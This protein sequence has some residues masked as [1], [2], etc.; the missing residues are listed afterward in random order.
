MKDNKKNRNTKRKKEKDY[1]SI[2]GMKIDGDIL[3]HV[4][5]PLADHSTLFRYLIALAACFSTIFLGMSYFDTG[6]DTFLI[7]MSTVILCTAFAIIKSEEAFIR[8][9]GLFIIAG[10]LL[11]FGLFYRKIANGFIL[12]YSKYLTKADRANAVITGIAKDIPSDERQSS[13]N[14]FMIL[15]VTIIAFGMVFSCLFRLNVPAMIIYS[16]PVFELGAY[17][18]WKP[19]TIYF[20]ILVICWTAVFALQLVNYSTNKAGLKNT[21]AIHP[22]KRTFYF[23]SGVF[24]KGFFTS[25]IKS[26][27]ALS[28]CIMLL[29]SIITSAIGKD[30]PDSLLQARRDLSNYIEDLSYRSLTNTLSDLNDTFLGNS[31]I[32]G[33][34]GGQLGK[35]DKINYNNTEALK[36]VIEDFK[37]PVYLKG[38]VAG[39]YDNNTWDTI[40]VDDELDDYNDGKENYIQ[41][42]GFN[43]IES[44]NQLLDITYGISEFSVKI[45]GA[46]KKYAYAPY[47]TS[48]A[49]DR[50][51]GG[52]K[53]KPSDESHVSLRARKYLMNYYNISACPTL[54]T[55]YSDLSAALINY[56]N[57]I[58]SNVTIDSEAQDLYYDFVIDKYLE[59]AE[60]V[61]LDKAVKD[62]ES[63]Y[64]QRSNYQ[65]QYYSG[66]ADYSS[67]MTVITAIQ[68]YFEEN[69]EYTLSPGKTPDGEDFID[70]FLSEQRKGYCSYFATAGVMLLRHFD[71]PARY[72]EGYVVYPNQLG[73][74]NEN[75]MNEIS[76]KDK[77]A[78][79]WAEIYTREL[80]WIPVE[81]TPGYDSSNPNIKDEKKDENKETTTTTTTTAETT[82]TTSATT[83][84]NT[85]TT[86]TTKSTDPEGDKTTTA[87][88]KTTKKS[89]N[90]NNSSQDESNGAGIIG[91]GNGSGGS[92]KSISIVLI[93]GVMIAAAILIIVL[94]RQYNLKK[95]ALKLTD[96]DTAEAVQNCYKASLKYLRLKGIGENENQTDNISSQKVSKK[97]AS[98]EF[99]DECRNGFEY[100]SEQAISAH[101]SDNEPDKTILSRCR[102]AL[103]NIKKE[104]S[105]KLSPFEK[106][107][108]SFI[109]NL[110]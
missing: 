21:F 31:N 85:P 34:N 7:G 25:F 78:H 83:N 86:T 47:F 82:T 11:T 58:K 94:R 104:T 9:L 36:L 69:F 95:M 51:E 62:I 93:Y 74:H 39:K 2:E 87:T 5:K 92:G 81:F 89:V 80:G 4:D 98:L 54:D 107:G 77:S 18:G 42:I 13:I 90:D 79:A 108:A 91:G 43:N 37:Y 24:K 27:V 45:K 63:N 52:E 49:S 17:W 70:Y 57:T 46:S 68:R 97:M 33:T 8:Y 6:A 99:S 29:L 71:I 73:G 48:Y 105:E 101:F 61:G 20:I 12:V 103:Q 75:G 41:D 65:A 50:N 22:R 40:E 96:S 88:K 106:L 38:F 102:L 66:F 16:F 19:D 3:L 44:Y 23:T 56:A 60:S 1:I 30:R 84:E 10:H 28:V 59:E 53:C 14:L 35:V 32:G 100:L 67:Y 15:L 72:V 64:I 109:K 76:V 55:R 110:Y 26:V